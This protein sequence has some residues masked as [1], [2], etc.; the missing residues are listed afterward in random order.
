MSSTLYYCTLVADLEIVQRSPHSY[1]SSYMPMGM[2][3]TVSWGGPHFSFKNSTNYPIRIEAKVEDGLVKIQLI[4]TDEK[5]YYVEMDY[6]VI[7]SQSPDTIYQEMYPDN[8][9]GYKDGQVIT[10]AYKGYTV[11]TYKLKYDKQTKEL[12]EKVEDRVSKYKKRDKVIA[13]IVP[14]PTQPPAPAP[15][16]EPAPAPADPAPD[17]SSSNSASSSSS[18]G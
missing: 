6:E 11:R 16:P 13:K 8:A 7:G 2:D 12:I 5:D 9:D 15:E 4:G 10:T 1:V 18:S 14:Y 17:S 3:A